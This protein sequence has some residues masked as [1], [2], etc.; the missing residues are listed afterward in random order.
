MERSPSPDP[1]VVGWLAP[2][3]VTSSCQWDVLVFLSQ[4]RTSQERLARVIYVLA[5]VQQR[6]REIRRQADERAARRTRWQQAI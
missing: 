5:D 2:L 4:H 1:E 3:G 6:L